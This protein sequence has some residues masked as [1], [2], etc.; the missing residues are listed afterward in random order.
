M[1]STTLPRLAVATAITLA[2]AQTQAESNDGLDGQQVA[3]LDPVIVTATRTPQTLQ[4][5]LSSVSVISREDI[6]RSQ[7]VDLPTLLERQP[8]LNVTRNG[9]F[10]QNTSV[11][12][13]GTN[14][15]HS[16]V[17]ID[18]M[19]IGS[20]TT[21]QTAF[22][23]L[24]LHDL[25]SIEIV[26]GPRSSIYGSDAIGGVVQMFTRGD[27]LFEGQRLRGSM[28]RGGNNT[29]EISAG[30]DAGDGD[31]EISINARKFDTDG[32]RVNEDS[33]SDNGFEN[34][35]ASLR[36]AQQLNDDV[37]WRLNA[38]HSRGVAESGGTTDAD[39]FTEFVQQ[40]VST[41]LDITATDWWQIN[42]RA[43]QSKDE[44]EGYLDTAPRDLDSRFNTSQEQA[45]WTNEFFLG[46]HHEIIAGVDARD[47]QV[48]STTDFD[49]DSRY[50]VGAFGVYLWDGERTDFEVSARRD[51]NE[52][53]G[54]S[55]T[56]GVASGYRIGETT[57]IRGSVGT[58]FNAPTFNDLFFPF[59]DFGTFGSF[60][61]NPDLD[62]EE[63]IS[64]EV[65]IEGGRDWRWS[66]VAFRTEIDDLIQNVDTTGA[67]D[68]QP[69]NVDE[70]VINGVEL[71]ATALD[72][73]GW[74][75]Q[76]AATW[77]DPVAKGKD[78]AD[79]TKLRRRP[80]RKLT[81]DADREIGQAN[82][83][84]SVRHEG[85]R[86]DDAANDD[87]LSQFTLLDFRVGYA[88]SDNVRLRGSV[89][90]AADTEYET[91]RG[92]NTLGRTFFLRLDYQG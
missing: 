92:F 14:S 10:G 22:E 34:D 37:Q 12:I 82:I 55:T 69:Q 29:S 54:D 35:S 89:I 31:R 78:G 1:Q 65:G 32:I 38:V 62:P 79:D 56:G 60:E 7:A 68:L 74:R 72:L 17:M 23:H 85:P 5:T 59:Q 40:T 15:D 24:P 48:D 11:F 91:V 57:R 45:S 75:L 25:E 30:I 87:K 88:L 28:M 47:D 27:A 46:D 8:G 51:R 13:R 16:L 58:A 20:A 81:F 19:R 61:G 76:G 21:G 80:Q 39:R 44:S 18:G 49:E 4:Q 63:S 43:G 36:Y 64:Y 26:R 66:A 73:D 2:C 52:T 9:A 84:F 70:A 3:S 42:L 67:G 86:F 41:Q 77:Q 50:N 33:R 53:F 71:S 6:D 83:G 90:N